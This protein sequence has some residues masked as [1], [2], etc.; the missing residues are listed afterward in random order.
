[1][2]VIRRL[3]RRYGICWEHRAVYRYACRPCQRRRYR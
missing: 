2:T 1:M 3:L